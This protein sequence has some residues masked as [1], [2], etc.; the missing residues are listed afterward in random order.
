MNRAMSVLGRLVMAPNRTYD[1]LRE[2]LRFLAFFVPSTLT[3]VAG[4]SL[5]AHLA[6]C[7]ILFTISA[8]RILYFEL[9][10]RLKP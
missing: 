2:P 1:R 10:D 3:V 7:V 5:D 6:M 4:H 9:T 8:Y